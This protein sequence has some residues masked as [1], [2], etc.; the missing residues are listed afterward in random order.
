[1]YPGLFSIPGFVSTLLAVVFATHVYNLC[2][3]RLQKRNVPG[4]IGV[5]LLG[6]LLQ[7]FPHRK[8][9]LMYLSILEE[10]Y[11]PMFAFNMPGYGR[12]IVINRPEWL[13]HM[14][15]SEN[16]L[17]KGRF[18]TLCFQEFPGSGSAFGSEGMKW[19][20]SRK[21]M[22]PVFVTPTFDRDVSHCMNE[23]AITAREALENVAKQGIAINFNVDF[24]GRLSL[25]VFCKMA[26][27][28]DM[29]LLTVDGSSLTNPHPLM[30]SLSILSEATSGRLF[31]PWWRLIEKA[32]FDGVGSKFTS[33]RAELFKIVEE[34]V[35]QR[36]SA[37]RDQDENYDFLSTL[38]RD[39]QVQDPALLRGTLIT[40]LFAAK[41]NTQNSLSWSLYEL[42]RSPV[43]L[44]KLRQEAF[45]NGDPTQIVQY[46]NLANYPNHLAVFYETIRLWP[47]VPKNTR[48]ALQDDVLPA[49]PAEGYGPVRVARGEYLLWSDYSMMRNEHVWGPDAREF[50]PARHLDTD[51]RFVKPPHPKFHSFGAGP[52]LCPGAQL[53]AYEF[54][55]FW[56]SVLPWFD[57]APVDGIARLPAD[58]LTLTMGEPLMVK[59]VRRSAARDLGSE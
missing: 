43:W 27:D 42:S 39:G 6:N 15:K 4:P 7:L 58:A 16:H 47:G 8:N 21:I 57:I 56:C 17:W 46:R 33:A 9:M 51:G 12:T 31:N 29:G 53:A 1:M 24:C 54:V 52:R 45:C 55:A 35:Q 59:V 10:K 11:G 50:N 41:D 22:K 37:G 13:E 32:S 2:I 18:Y 38:L 49:I 40:L 28:Y 34:I 36:K 30:K 19:R 25:E 14:R 20:S 48:V 44:E 5:P 23:V 3:I 26:L